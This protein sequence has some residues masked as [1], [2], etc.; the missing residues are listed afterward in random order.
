MNAMTDH[1]EGQAILRAQTLHT[2]R[3]LCIAWAY[4][5][6]YCRGGQPTGWWPG[7]DNGGADRRYRAP[8]QWYP[9]GPRMPE[10]DENAG[11]A[12]QRAYIHLP[13][14]LY[15]KILRVEFCFCSWVLEAKE[16]E[17]DVY[18]A[19]RARVSLGAYQITLERALFAL[20]NV[21]KRRGLWREG[22]TTL[23]KVVS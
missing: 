8:P 12:V 17:A 13:E 6:I 7:M 2:A 3:E 18:V 10:A 23:G 14:S 4:W 9:Q 22:L 5:C 15:R 19:R 16:G 11:L 20:V 1:E 21:M